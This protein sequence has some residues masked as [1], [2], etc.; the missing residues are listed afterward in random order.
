M[1]RTNHNDE[2]YLKE[3]YH[4]SQVR[5]DP[6]LYLKICQTFNNNISSSIFWKQNV[7]R[8]NYLTREFIAWWA[9]LQSIYKWSL[10]LMEMENESTSDAWEAKSLNL[11]LSYTLFLHYQNASMIT[12]SLPH[13]KHICQ[14]L[15]WNDITC[16]K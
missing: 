8:Y 7:A 14:R 5:K 2:C 6:T 13:E 9:I 4:N 1:A 12:P 16:Q 15:S 11:Q 10:G 3:Q